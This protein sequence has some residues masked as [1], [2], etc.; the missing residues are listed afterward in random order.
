MAMEI[1]VTR[2]PFFFSF[3]NSKKIHCGAL[4]FEYKCYL[5]VMLGTMARRRKSGK[6]VIARI[7]K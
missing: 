6:K 4:L 2:L 1:K 7:L 5:D 3:Y